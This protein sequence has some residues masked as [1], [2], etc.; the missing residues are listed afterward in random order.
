MSVASLYT[1]CFVMF[2][3]F[4]YGSFCHGAHKLDLSTLFTTCFLCT[5]LPFIISFSEAQKTLTG[6][7]LKA[8]FQMNK[9]LY[10]FTYVNVQHRQDLYDKLIT[11]LMNY[12]GEVWEFI[13]ENSIEKVHMQFCKK[14]LG[15]KANTQND[16]IYGELG[17]VNFQSTDFIL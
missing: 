3:V 5:S 14:I 17:R 10:K 15:V 13:K 9:R 2:C 8:I 1:P 7:S 6:H 16:F 11:P 4:L 12:A